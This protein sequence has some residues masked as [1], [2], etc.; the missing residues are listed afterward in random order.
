MRAFFYIRDPNYVKSVAPEE[1]E[2]YVS[3]SPES[4][5]KLARLKGEIYNSQLPLREYKNPN[6]FATQV[7]DDLRLV[8]STDCPQRNS[9][10]D[11]N[12][13]TAMEYISQLTFARSRALAYVID[14]YYYDLYV[15]PFENL[16]FSN[17]KKKK[18][19]LHNHTLYTKSKEML[20]EYI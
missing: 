12:D 10:E 3:E 6:Q 16:F 19:E 17:K 15:S 20:R 14:S 13:N 9:V 18:K 5:Q 7:L 4:A 11:L 8:I 2:Y 1:R